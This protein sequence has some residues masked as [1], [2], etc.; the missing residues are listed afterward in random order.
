MTAERPLAQDTSLEA[1]RQQLE[2]WGAMTPAEKFALLDD[3][4]ASSV[5]FVE[6]GIRLRHPQAGPEEV[7]LR[8]LALS[9]GRELVLRVYGFD[10]GA[11]A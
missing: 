3:L 9:L 10:V 7:R 6:A 2:I 4:H 8:R 5:L 1:E 11:G